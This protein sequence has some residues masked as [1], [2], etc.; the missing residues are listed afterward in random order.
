[1]GLEDIKD[2]PSYNTSSEQLTANVLWARGEVPFI[3]EHEPTSLPQVMKHKSLLYLFDSQA[4]VSYG[5]DEEQGIVAHIE[6]VESVY[7]SPFLQDI[8]DFH[9]STQVC[10]P[11]RPRAGTQVRY[12]RLTPSNDFA[13][14]RASTF[15]KSKDDYFCKVPH[16]FSA[17]HFHI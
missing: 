9:T 17:D 16:I 2:F 12:Y 7:D 10:L 6:F 5:A 15:D 3:L 13:F 4:R 1:M 8:V 11:V 14:E